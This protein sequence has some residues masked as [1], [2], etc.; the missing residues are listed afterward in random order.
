MPKL[1]MTPTSKL[2]ESEWQ[3]L[4]QTFVNKGMIG[5]SDAGTLLGLN[6]YKSP[7]NLFYQAIGL[8]QLPNKMNHIMLHGKQLED[9]V[10]QCWQYYDGT[11]DGWVENTLNKNKIKTYKKVKS[12]I[13]NPAYPALFANIDGQITKHPVY[14]KKKGILEIKTISGYSADSYEAGLP[15]SYLLQVQH[16]MLVTGYKYAEICYLKDGRDLGLVTFDADPELQATIL[17]E[18]TKFQR[19]VFEA[20]R[21]IEEYKTAHPY[22]EQDELYGIVANLE[23]EADDSEAFNYFISEKHKARE[24]EVKM[25][26]NDEH[27]EWLESYVNTSAELK[28][29]ESRKQLYQNRLKQVMEQNQASVM[30]LPNGKITWRKQF[31]ATLN[32][33]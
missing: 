22:A 26:G 23:P 30:M 16:Y 20:R 12:I 18:A 11:P 25:Q 29:V 13:T 17:D 9:Y 19:R 33:N 28:E 6:K 27:Q 14:G 8:S 4:R 2:T 5:G 21:V 10:A 24:N 32:K 31:I 15:P 3:T 1:I 7:I